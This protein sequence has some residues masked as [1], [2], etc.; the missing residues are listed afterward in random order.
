MT[1]QNVRAEKT[2]L[3]NLPV[4]P[5]TKK[6]KIL[7]LR[8]LFFAVKVWP[9][10]F[11]MF[12][13]LFGHPSD[14][15]IEWFLLWKE[16][17]RG[18]PG[19]NEKL[20]CVCGWTSLKKLKFTTVELPCVWAF[21]FYMYVL[22][23]L[24][25]GTLTALCVWLNCYPYGPKRLSDFTWIALYVVLNC[26][27]IEREMHCVRAWIIF[28]WAWTSP[29]S[30][31]NFSLYVL[32]FS[33]YGVEPLCVWDIELPCVWAS[34]FSLYVTELLS[35]WHLNCF[36]YGLK[37]I[38]VWAWTSPWP[39]V[40]FSLYG[41]ELMCVWDME[42]PSIWASNFSLYVFELLSF[43]TWTALC[44]SLN[45]YMCGPELLSDFDL[46]CI[47]FSPKLLPGQVWTSL[48]MIWTSLGTFWTS[49]C[50]GWTTVCMGYR[51]ALCMGFELLYICY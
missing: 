40:N 1:T 17:V 14:L 23:L 28:V 37:I 49:L 22:E 8:G 27:L 2:H 44:V 26:S 10:L 5:V 25:F 21:N 4:S 13:N 45:C 16:R 36:V 50:M 41:V 9:T 51:T 38:S 33:L 3:L 15:Q 42:L 29:W 6:L 47:V 48:C 20:L 24:S 19:K 11:C 34:N 12:K 31:V 35:F 7:F 18:F 43:V 39:V 32:N 46:N 30:V